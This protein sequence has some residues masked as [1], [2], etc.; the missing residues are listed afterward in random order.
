[1]Q[2]SISHDEFERVKRCQELARREHAAGSEDEEVADRA[3]RSIDDLTRR[4]R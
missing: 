3:G 2:L 1:M 4:Y